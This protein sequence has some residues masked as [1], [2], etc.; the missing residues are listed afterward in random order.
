VL[1]PGKSQQ[2]YLTGWYN[3]A[4]GTAVDQHLNVLTG[5]YPASCGGGM[6]PGNETIV[7]FPYPYHG[8]DWCPNF[9]GSGFTAVS[10][11]A[12][13]LDQSL[14]YVADYG[15]ASVTVMSYPSGTLVT[16]LGI[17]NGLTDPQ[18]IAA[19]PAP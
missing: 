9:L 15:A 5:A 12:L 19:G 17:A 16:T 11:L 13:S 1:I 7:Q 14:L 4:G 18:G 2:G 6:A 8:S 10:G 3:P